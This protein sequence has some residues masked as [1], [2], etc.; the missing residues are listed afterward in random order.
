V[1]VLGAH[2]PESTAGGDA[3]QR[4]GYPTTFYRTELT[5]QV[6][7]ILA[8][9]A[10]LTSQ[11]RSPALRLVG[12]GDAALP[13]LLSRVVAGPALAVSQ[14]IVDLSTIDAAV[15]A[16]KHPALLRLAAGRR[17]VAMPAGFRRPRKKFDAEPLRAS[18]KAAGREGRL[19]S[20]TRRSRPDSPGQ[21][22]SSDELERRVFFGDSDAPRLTTFVLA[23]VYPL[24]ATWLLHAGWISFS[25]RPGTAATSV[26][27]CCSNACGCPEDVKREGLLLQQVA[28]GPGGHEIRPA[29]RDQSALRE[30]KTR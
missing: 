2:E 20:P 3:S 17:G 28:P 9:L 15:D 5:R 12:V 19:R 10:R 22:G 23:A 11:G 21:P 7:D 4:K 27:S 13:V 8:E 26:D 29:Q 25:P 30:P 24:Q 16:S 1:L 14:T 6:E 18:Y